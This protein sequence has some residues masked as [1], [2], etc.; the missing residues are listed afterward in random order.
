MEFQNL[1]AIRENGHSKRE[2]LQVRL[3][4]FLSRMQLCEFDNIGVMNIDASA[5]GVNAL[6]GD[7]V[8]CE[9]S[10]QSRFGYAQMCGSFV[11]SE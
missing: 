6:C 3:L 2:L 5:S 1:H 8:L 7:S 11:Q 9:P 4:P 10:S